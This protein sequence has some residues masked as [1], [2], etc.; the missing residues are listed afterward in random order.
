MALNV[1]LSWYRSPQSSTP[2][3]SLSQQQQQPFCVLRCLLCKFKT[4][5]KQQLKMHLMGSGRTVLNTKC[6]LCGQL[7]S[8]ENPDMCMIK[9]HLLLHLGCHIMC[10]QCGFTVSYTLLLLLFV[11][12]PTSY[13][14]KVCV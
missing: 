2:S 7:L 5:D 11:C 12:V 1:I 3:S 8:I 10:P 13:K 9:A 6:G 4:N 14:S